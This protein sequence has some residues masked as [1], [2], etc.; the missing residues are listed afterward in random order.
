MSPVEKAQAAATAAAQR[1]L[2]RAASFVGL[3]ATAKPLFQKTMR[4]GS[5]SLLVRLVWPGVLLVCDPA[6][7]EVLAQSVAGEP[8]HLAR[9]F[10]PGTP[11]S[12]EGVR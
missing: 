3:H 7:G 2:E 4:V 10:V 8:M 9:G 6:T 5:R 12:S 1:T 11:Y